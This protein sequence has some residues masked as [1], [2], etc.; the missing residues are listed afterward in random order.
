MSARLLGTASTGFVIP[1][2]VATHDVADGEGGT[3][4]QRWSSGATMARS[5]GSSTRRGLLLPLAF[6]QPTTLQPSRY[7]GPGPW[8]PASSWPCS[9]KTPPCPEMMATGRRSHLLEG[10]AHSRR[11]AGP[12]RRPGVRS[13]TDE[14]RRRP[15]GGRG[16]T[17]GVV[18]RLSE[19]VTTVETR[20]PSPSSTSLPRERPSAGSRTA[21]RTTSPPWRSQMANWASNVPARCPAVLA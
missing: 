21:W 1:A 20:S 2:H 4:V 7:G 6:V 16:S 9:R 11:S 19:A 5:S 17:P 18:V 10:S 3:S 14:S 13:E 15:L 12:E 8:C